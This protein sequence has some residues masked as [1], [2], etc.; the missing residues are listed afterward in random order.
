MVFIKG[1]FSA[2]SLPRHRPSAPLAQSATERCGVPRFPRAEQVKPPKREQKITTQPSSRGERRGARARETEGLREGEMDDR[3]MSGGG[4]RRPRYI[5]RVRGGDTR[6][7]LVEV[8][9]EKKNGP[10]FN[11]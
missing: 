5:S 7:N 8:I 2:A 6:R 9:V 3:F 4:G 10:R 11:S 1:E